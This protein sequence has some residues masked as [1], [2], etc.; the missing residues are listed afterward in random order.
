MKKKRVIFIVLIF[1]TILYIPSVV[2]F[3]YMKQS[4]DDMNSIKE[5][6]ESTDLSDIKV[7]GYIIGDKFR[8]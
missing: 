3:I 1:L 4:L 7:E 5:N 6:L 2:K 8:N